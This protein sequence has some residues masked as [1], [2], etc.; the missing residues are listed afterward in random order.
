MEFKGN[1]ADRVDF[2]L[3]NMRDK[4]A[5]DFVHEPVDIVDGYKIISVSITGNRATVLVE[6]DIV[7]ELRTVVYHGPG[8]EKLPGVRLYRADRFIPRRDPNY[9]QKLLW[10]FKRPEGMWYLTSS[11]IPKVSKGSLLK[12]LQAEVQRDTNILHDNPGKPL[13]Y[14]EAERTWDMEKIKLVESVNSAAE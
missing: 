13:P 4:N 8:A 11:Q 3:S 7:G 9:R 14:L 6:Y 12:L 1:H 2:F 10:T 5:V